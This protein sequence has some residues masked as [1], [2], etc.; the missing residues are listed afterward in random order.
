MILIG[1]GSTS[2][3]S[4]KALEVGRSPH[5][6]FIIKDAEQISMYDSEMKLMG[7][8]VALGRLLPEGVLEMPD[9]LFALIPQ[10]DKPPNLLLSASADAL[11]GDFVPSQQSK[12]G[13]K[14]IVSR[15]QVQSSEEQYSLFYDEKFVCHVHSSS[16]VTFK[17]AEYFVIGDGDDLVMLSKFCGKLRLKCPSGV[18]AIS[19]GAEWL[20]D[21]TFLIVCEKHIAISSFSNN[22]QIIKKKC[23]GAL[24]SEFYRGVV[25]IEEDNQLSVLPVSFSGDTF[26]LLS[27]PSQVI[28]LSASHEIQV[29]SEYATM[30][31][32]RGIIG[33]A[34]KTT[35]IVYGPKGFCFCDLQARIW[36]MFGD[37]LQEQSFSVSCAAWLGNDLAVVCSQ[38]GFIRIFSFEKDLDLREALVSTRITSV[39]KKVFFQFQSLL[40]FDERGDLTLLDPKTM[41]SLS[42][43]HLGSISDFWLEEVN[44]TKVLLILKEGS[45]FELGYN[46]LI[47]G[48]GGEARLCI[49]LDEPI[50]RFV[51]IK[52]PAVHALT[53]TLCLLPGNKMKLVG[54]EHEIA[55]DL[56]IEEGFCFAGIAQELFS[57][58]AKSIQRSKDL[59]LFPFILKAFV[60][61]D[62]AGEASLLLK[63]WADDERLGVALEHVLAQLSLGD[64]VMLTRFHLLVSEFVGW[65]IYRRTVIKVARTLELEDAVRL[66]QATVSLEELMESAMKE[67][68][69]QVLLMGL[70]LK[71]A[72]DDENGSW[73]RHL[74]NLL[75][76]KHKVE[77]LVQA[78]EFVERA[79]P[80]QLPLLEDVLR[81]GVRE[82]YQNRLYLS[83]LK[84]VPRFIKEC[85]AV[86]LVEMPLEKRLALIYFQLEINPLCSKAHELKKSNP[87]IPQLIRDMKRI[88][89]EDQDWKNLLL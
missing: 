38:D 10:S 76:S 53:W 40:V 66:F 71:L 48:G 47:N 39:A 85:D 36:K 17:Q 87:N 16:P 62:W 50:V 12:I 20:G 19:K 70:R 4:L 65:S 55:I 9:G 30:G 15:W 68:D 23:R 84:L 2:K 7:Q 37:P 43:A 77:E 13:L 41:Q 24:W 42:K 60:E 80:E 27:C 73:L 26:S 28:N 45:L 52:D 33:N 6:D 79:A 58:Q 54:L 61:G 83:V 89:I 46:S 34:T 31:M 51:R 22:L 14:R 86:E 82:L 49:K 59:W 64:K 35:F 72:V 11:E 74:I 5:F 78:L 63:Y 88:G 25:Y 81:V 3:L 56:E 69:V 8:L 67:E 57:I 21:D 18:V 75:L 44:E 29:G 32:L 1:S